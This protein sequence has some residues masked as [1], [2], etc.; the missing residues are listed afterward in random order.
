MLPVNYSAVEVA[1]QQ[2][3]DMLRAAQQEQLARQLDRRPA[4][5]QNLMM[6]KLGTLLVSVGRRLQ[7][8]AAQ[9]QP[10]I[11]QVS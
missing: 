10:C 5:S 4:R 9:T 2:R 11:E 3:Q 7:A 8:P 6:V 1:R